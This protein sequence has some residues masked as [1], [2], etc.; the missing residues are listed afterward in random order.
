M[1]G[2]PPPRA[3]PPLR[4]APAADAVPGH[5]AVEC[6]GAQRPPAIG[7]GP[8]PG[9]KTGCESV[10]FGA[11]LAAATTVAAPAGGGYAGAMLDP[12]ADTGSLFF[13]LLCAAA[14]GFISG[15]A[16]FGTALVASEFWFHALPAPLVPPLV[17]AA[18]V[19]GQ[20]VGFV[21]VHRAFEWGRALPFIL[22]GAAGVP[23]GVAAL[24]VAS[25]DALRLSVGVFLAAY[26]AFQLAGLARFAIGAWGGRPAD[27]AV[28]LVSGGLGGFAG[29]SGALP[30]VWL[31][32]R[33][34]PSEAQR[35]TYQPFNLVILGLAAV[36]MGVAGKLDGAVLALAALSLP[37]TLASA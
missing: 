26:A 27:A 15:F 37:V 17:V 33:G 4:R 30:L 32:M 10:G 8:V 20:L 5:A 34:G 31:Q 1:S 9:K 14:A 3:Q 28:G 18:G 13:V 24:I 7:A 2:P 6:G 36:G 21:K 12:I 23:L 29:L 25:P 11:A 35:A 22:P 16:G 19:A